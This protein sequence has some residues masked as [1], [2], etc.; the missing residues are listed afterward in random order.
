MFTFL[1]QHFGM[2]LTIIAGISVLQTI[3]DHIRG[4]HLE[5]QFHQHSMVQRFRERGVSGRCK[6][7]FKLTGASRV[8]DVVVTDQE[9]WIKGIWPIFTYIGSTSGLTHKIPLVNIKHVAAKGHKAELWFTD[10]SNKEYRVE[11]SI[12]RPQEFISSIASKSS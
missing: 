1:D 2:I 5:K 3:A 6:R 10:V 12:K 8:L 9:L 11:I 7:P 4:R